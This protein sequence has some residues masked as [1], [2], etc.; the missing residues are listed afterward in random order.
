MNTIGMIK[1]IDSWPVSVAGGGVIAVWGGL[2]PAIRVI[3]LFIFTDFV[4]GTYLSVINNKFKSKKLV[5]KTI[6]KIF[7]YTA[8]MIL[9]IGFE[10]F[11]GVSGIQKISIGVVF[12]KEV[13]SILSNI[14]ALGVIKE[15]EIGFLR[16]LVLATFKEKQICENCPDEEC[17]L[18]C[19]I[20]KEK[21]NGVR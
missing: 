1:A 2:D 10:I 6:R 11:T 21:R 14:L 18:V 5:D 4:L 16:G 13:F 3:P 15:K 17:H 8:L 9:S 20:L 7:S 12:A 19:K